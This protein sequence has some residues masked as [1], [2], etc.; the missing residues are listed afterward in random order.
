MVEETQ[1]L[2]INESFRFILFGLECA[3]DAELNPSV[4]E[5]VFSDAENDMVSEK[6]YTFWSG[7]SVEVTGHI[8]GYEP[9]SLW[10]MVRSRQGCKPSLSEIAER[11]KY[12]TLR[13]AKWQEVSN[14]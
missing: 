2:S 4:L 7:P 12:H 9:E 1:L 10:L 13:W 14:V 11:A 5:Q 6:R 8:E 3:L